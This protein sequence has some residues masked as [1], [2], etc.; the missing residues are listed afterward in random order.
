[1]LF[2]MLSLRFQWMERMVFNIFISNRVQG[3]EGNEETENGFEGFICLSS[4]FSCIITSVRHFEPMWYRSS[5]DSVDRIKDNL[6]SILV[7][8]GIST[9]SFNQWD[10]N[11]NMNSNTYTTCKCLSNWQ[12]SGLYCTVGSYPVVLMEDRTKK[13]F[14]SELTYRGIKYHKTFLGDE[15][16]LDLPVKI[17][18]TFSG[19]RRST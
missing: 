18:F 3:R 8:R 2:V 6:T 16:F 7:I 17:S 15:N 1:M 9:N 11:I 5:E 10:L 13:K 19:G 14:I 12:K 4:S